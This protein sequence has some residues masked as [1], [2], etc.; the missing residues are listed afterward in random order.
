MPL[1]NREEAVRIYLQYLS[2]PDKLIDHAAI[3][4]LQTEADRAKDPLDKLRALGAL[5]RAKAVDGSYFEDGFV[6]SARQWAEEEGVPVSAFRSMGVS[7]DVLSR[8]GLDGTRRRSARSGAKRGGGRAPRAKSTST[9]VIK[10][11]VLSSAESFTLS[12]VQRAIGGSPA[13]IKK[14]IDEL[15]TDGHVTNMGPVPDHSGRGRAPYHY[16]VEN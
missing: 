1:V 8:A 14:A 15:I 5:E 4:K 3:K 13:T 9:E 12:D 16:S 6:Q 10:G 7:E 2:D 11:W